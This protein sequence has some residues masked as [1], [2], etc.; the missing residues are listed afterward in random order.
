MT[1]SLRTLSLLNSGKFPWSDVNCSIKQFKFPCNDAFCESRAPRSFLRKMTLSCLLPPAPLKW[2]LGAFLCWFTCAWASAARARAETSS[3]ASLHAAVSHSV[4]RMAPSSARSSL[5]VC[6][7]SVYLSMTMSQSKTS[8]NW[9]YYL[10]KLH[11]VVAPP[12]SQV[13]HLKICKFVCGSL[14]VWQC[15][16]SLSQVW[17]KALFSCISNNDA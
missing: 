2:R 9:E 5:T 6:F 16:A 7:L 17:I 13:V 8:C 1:W 15:L 4:D 3:C 14:A 10:N 12:L 11:K